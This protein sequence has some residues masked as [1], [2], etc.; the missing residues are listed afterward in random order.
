VAWRRFKGD[1]GRYEQALEA[2]R[3]G[4]PLGQWRQ[5]S[6]LT[7]QLY[8]TLDRLIDIDLDHHGRVSALARREYEH[9]FVLMLLLLGAALVLGGMVVTGV[10]LLLRAKDRLLD[11]QYQ[12]LAQHNADLDAFAGRVA[13]D[14]RAALTPMVS[15]ADL[16]SRLVASPLVPHCERIQRRGRAL[17]YFVDALLQFAKAGV[18][19]E[20]VAPVR[21][22]LRAVAATVETRAPVIDAPPDL[23]AR[24]APALLESIAGNLVENAYK[25]SQEAV[26]L[27]AR[28][29]GD[30]VVITVADRGIGMTPEV[31]ARV[32]DPFYRGPGRTEPGHG[33]GLATVKRIVEAHGGV[34]S[35]SSTPGVGSAFTVRLPAA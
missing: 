15:S 4:D 1:Y 8:D 23:S 12:L 29:E 14:V 34:I 32:F 5:L 2:L 16:L 21:E 25:Y 27:G 24:I 17:A 3:P 7:H 13:H 22:T 10:A 9:A 6:E 35:V 31:A 30:E 33:L 28:R 26:S 20:G 19:S 11:A 18:K